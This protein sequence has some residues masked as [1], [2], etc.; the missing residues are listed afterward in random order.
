MNLLKKTTFAIAASVL[1]LTACNKPALTDAALAIPKDAMSVT[2]INIQSL[3]QKA[4]FEAVKNMEFYKETVAKAEKDNPATAAIMKNP[5]QSGIDLTKN[6][7]LAQ[8]LDLSLGTGSAG[9]TILMTIAD[10]KAFELMIQN[11]SKNAKIETKEGVKYLL[12]E[13]ETSSDETGYTVNSNR[14]GFVAWNDKLAVIGADFGQNTEG[15]SLAFLKYFK[16]NPAESIAQNDKLKAL[17]SSPHD[18]YSF[19][20]FDKLANNTSAKAAAGAM[21]LDPKAL[22]GNY[23]TGFSDFDKGQITS[24]SD[25]NINPAITKE[26]G[27]MFKNNVKTDFSKYV[28]PDLGFAVTMG[29]DA[30]GIKEIINSNS[31][32]K[33]ATEGAKGLYNFSVDDLIKALD[34]DMV[35]TASPTG[36]DGKW[37]GAM[38]FKIGDKPT[39][40][41]FMDALV[42]NEILVKN[43]ENA[44]SFANS[45]NEMAKS[46]VKDG[47]KIVFVDDIMFAGDDATIANLKGQNKAVSSDVK[48]V[49]NKNIFGMYANF[50]KIFADTEGMQNP[51]MAEMKMYLNGK[52]GEGVLK[53]KNAN[54]NSLKSLMQALN[55]WYLQDKMKKEKVEL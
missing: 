14:S 1:F 49:L 15:G 9:M 19:V 4:D 48:D 42:G 13:G 24:K 30:K 40:M 3:M 6:I 29:L 2:A 39:L 52:G 11:G 54:E 18:M 50:N 7:Y 22:K 43:G 12:N 25:F 17:M 55:R 33:M 35:I 45:A 46:Y 20:T 41:K 10:V 36:K 21:N 37:T 16:T 28:N 32:F 23:F 47:G 26:W 51:E 5:A 53:M 27:L 44:Y 38:G 31:Q 8:D 34:G